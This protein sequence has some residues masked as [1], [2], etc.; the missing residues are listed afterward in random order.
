MGKIGTIITRTPFRVSF[1]GG[2]TDLPDYFNRNAGAVLGTTINKYTY[3]VLNNLERL[4]EKKIK[5]SYSKLEIV[6]N[7]EELQHELVRQVLINSKEMLNGSFIDIHSFADLPHS[8]GVGSSSCFI[9]GFLNAIYQM[10]GIYKSPHE[11]AR[12]AIF[13]E[14]EQLKHD[15]GWQDQVHASYGGFNRIDFVNSEYHV[16]PVAITNA[17]QKA[18][19]SSCMFYFTGI[20]RSSAEVI[21]SAFVESAGKPSQDQQDSYLKEMYNMV[22]EGIQILMNS[23]NE[24][25]LISEFGSLLHKAWNCKRALSNSISTSAIDEMYATAMKAG[26]YGGKLLGAGGG[27]CMLFVVPENKKESVSAA[28]RGLNRINIGFERQGSRTIFVNH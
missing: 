6:E 13:I 26:A 24:Q 16:S 21:K 15:G 4:Q 5:L 9:V 20:K 12:E 27:G 2:G 11:I 25:E 14:R 19:E 10:H 1:F 22:D 23:G 17:R 8:S 3:V 28:M 7:P 18:L